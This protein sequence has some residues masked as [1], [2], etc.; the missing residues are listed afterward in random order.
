MSK[1]I[2]NEREKTHGDYKAVAAVAQSI[3]TALHLGKNNLPYIAQESLELIATKMARI[4]CGDWR[5]K[6]HWNDISGYAL[7]ISRELKDE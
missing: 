5:E 4:V 6:D 7:L 2:L 1:E 3:K